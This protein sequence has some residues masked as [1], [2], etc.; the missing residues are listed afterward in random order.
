[1]TATA[2]LEKVQLLGTDFPIGATGTYP[3][4]AKALD[5]GVSAKLNAAALQPLG[6]HPRYVEELVRD[7]AARIANCLTIRE[8]A[9]DLEVRAI[10]DAVNYKLQTESLATEK[11]I[12]EALKPIRHLKFDAATIAKVTK[13]SPTSADLSATFLGDKAIWTSVDT[14]ESDFEDTRAAVLDTL[15]LKASV[16]GNGS[17]YAERFT[18]FKDLFDLNLTEA[19]R[20]ALVCAKAI[21][22]IYSIDM[23][24]PPMVE[25]G[26]LNLLALWAQRSSDLLDVELDGREISEVGFSM[27]APA[28]DVSGYELMPRSQFEASV[29]AGTITFSISDQNLAK[30]GLQKPLLRSLRVLVKAK[31]ET[32]IRMWPATIKAPLSPLIAEIPTISC[33]AASQVASGASEQMQAHGVHNINP[34]GQWQ[35]SF[36][37]RS[38]TGE[39]SSKDEILNVYL[40]LTI[41]HKR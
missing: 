3:S 35:L 1:M 28:E 11:A 12:R 13:E 30:Y 25:S 23:P 33:V 26:F 39:S 20:R 10:G 16:A 22:E 19:Y 41:S 36:A 40:L 5:D 14:S 2:W 9:Q 21:K 34:I 38:L 24:V 37:G 27:A 7:C 18:F 32:R 15:K 29:T 31:D 8:K 17:N 4:I 6:V